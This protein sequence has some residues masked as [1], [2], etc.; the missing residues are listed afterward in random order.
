MKAHV[1]AAVKRGVSPAVAQCLAQKPSISLMHA[2]AIGVI[3]LE[4]TV[5]GGIDNARAERVANDILDIEY[6]LASF[7]T[8]RF[9]TK[10]SR[11]R[12]RFHD[13][14]DVFTTT[15]VS[16]AAREAGSLYAA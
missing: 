9:L 11:A 10:D 2:M 5:N 13:L 3:A 14:Q 16:G 7:W 15:Q 12:D 8:S 4:W 1:N 6:V